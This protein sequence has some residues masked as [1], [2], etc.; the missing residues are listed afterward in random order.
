MFHIPSFIKS[1]MPHIPTQRELD[2]AYL[3]E[4]VDIYDVERRMAEI[5]HRHNDVYRQAP[6]VNFQLH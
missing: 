5:D 6:V 1:L 4:S 2:I 3:N